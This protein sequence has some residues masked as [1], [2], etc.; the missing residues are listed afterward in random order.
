MAHLTKKQLQERLLREFVRRILEAAPDER[1]YM[2][3]GDLF[4]AA[5]VHDLSDA[6]AARRVAAVRNDDDEREDGS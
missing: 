5:E 4:K 3:V 1:V 6:R 2:A